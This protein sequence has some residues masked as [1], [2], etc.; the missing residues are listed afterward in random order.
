MVRCISWFMWYAGNPL[1]PSIF[2]PSGCPSDGLCYAQE[3]RL[4]RADSALGKRQ[5]VRM[6]FSDLCSCWMLMAE[7][8]SRLIIAEHYQCR[9]GSASSAV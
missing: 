7:L 9:I 1:N 2:E 4:Q 5:L 3:H 8:V 6:W